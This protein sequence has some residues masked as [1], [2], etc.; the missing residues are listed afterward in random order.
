MLTYFYF[1][2]AGYDGFRILNLAN[3][4]TGEFYDDMQIVNY[5]GLSSDS[6]MIDA[7]MVLESRSESWKQRTDS[8]GK[9]IPFEYEMSAM[10]DAGSV[11]LKVASLK[12]PVYVGDSGYF[13]Q[14]ASSFTYY[15][16]QTRNAIT[17]TLSFQGLQ[18]EVSGTGWID[19][20]FGQFN[21]L[22]AERYEWFSIQLSNN[23]ELNVW[24]LFT[25][26][27]QLPDSP[28]F[29]HITMIDEEANQ[30]TTDDFDLERLSYFFT[31]D[32]VMCYAERWRLTVPMHQIDLIIESQHRNNEVQ[33]PFR[34][35]EGSTTISG[36]VEGTPVTGQGF[37]E[38]V[39]G[40]RV[41]EILM[42]SPVESSWNPSEPVQWT[43]ENPDD[44]NPLHYDLEF[45]SDTLL[46]FSVIG[47]GITDTLFLWEDP[48]L[49][50]GQE[51]WFRVKGYSVDTT[52]VSYSDT[53]RVT[54]QSSGVSNED[55]PPGD[56]SAPAFLVYP[57]PARDRLF[58]TLQQPGTREHYQI[59]DSAG[60]AVME[61]LLPVSGTTVSVDIHTLEPGPYIIRIS[62]MGEGSA[63]SFQISE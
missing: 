37:A 33:F 6:L 13:K 16:S 55:G 44:G 3:D 40:Y 46:G 7:W 26:E 61:G 62:G 34:F 35:F 54:V 60:K 5:T 47:Q 63:I 20:Q 2:Y 41:P 58:I 25:G 23:M 45:T 31:P 52:I 17:G 28:A 11:D 21:T 1:P 9:I 15:Y 4:D 39:K 29:K 14:G 18:E 53:L 22:S 50:E 24:N 30:L 38:L 10:S 27:N 51:A 42:H 48:T 59:F 12:P 8:M 19:R 49:T 32:S 57:N 56:K 43:L 36:T